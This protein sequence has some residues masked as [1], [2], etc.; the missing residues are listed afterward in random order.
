VSLTGFICSWIPAR[1]RHPGS[2]ES[3]YRGISLSTR[4]ADLLF[5]LIV[6][7]SGVVGVKY[8]TSMGMRKL[9][10]RLRG[11]QYDL[12]KVK[13]ERR[14]KEDEQNEMSDEEEKCEERIRSM[15]DIINDLEYR[16]TTSKEEEQE[17]IF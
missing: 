5:L 12:D 13:K 3:Q 17:P 4:Q 2:V 6:A 15:K 10:R 7:F 1:T 9:E 8:Y 16:L 14:E 11:V